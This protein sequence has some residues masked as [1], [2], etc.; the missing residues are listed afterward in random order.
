MPGSTGIPSFVLRGRGLAGSRPHRRRSG[1]L[2]VV[3]MT[4]ALSRC[5]VGPRAHSRSL[6]TARGHNYLPRGS[7]NVVRPREQKLSWA[8][9]ANE[10]ANT[11][12]GHAVA[13]PSSSADFART[14]TAASLAVHRTVRDEAILHRLKCFVV[15]ADRGDGKR[16]EERPPQVVACASLGRHG[17]VRRLASGS[18]CR[19]Q[20]CFWLVAMTWSR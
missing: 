12:F 11:S 9:D 8:F 6:E 15:D 3:V 5:R 17:R 20:R 10:K 18:S 2:F 13:H 14:S 7:A 19:Q 4:S 1:T 16:N